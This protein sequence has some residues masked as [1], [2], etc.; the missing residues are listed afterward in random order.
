MQTPYDAMWQELGLDMEAHAGLLEFLGK[1]YGDIFLPQPNRPKAMGYFDFVVSE[2]HGL[3]VK[4]LL[5]AKAAGRKIIASF[6]VFVPEEVILAAGGV[7]IGLCGGAEAGFDQA[8]RHLPQNTCALIKSFFG[9][10]LAR[11]CPYIEVADLVVGETT[12]DGKKKA[13]EVFGEFAPVHVMELP[14]CKG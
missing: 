5:E 6:C 13:Y 3:R 11:L 8:E 9:F 4:E 1:A 7:S 14:Q 10:K 2:I 12:C